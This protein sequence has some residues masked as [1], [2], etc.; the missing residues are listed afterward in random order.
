[1]FKG[2]SGLSMCHFADL[3]EANQ[4]YPI[5]FFTLAVGIT[6]AYRLTWQNLLCV[7]RV[8]IKLVGIDTLHV[9]CA[10][11]LQISCLSYV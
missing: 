9:L 4:L 10:G 7:D 6:W 8:V 1:M 3:N 11:M 5:S 2:V